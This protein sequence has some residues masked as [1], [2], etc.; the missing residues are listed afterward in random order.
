MTTTKEPPVR[1]SDE[2]WAGLDH[3]TGVLTR[4]QRLRVALL[5]GAVVA[6]PVLASVGWWFGVHASVNADVSVSDVDR[7]A[8]TF[9]VTVTVYNDSHLAQ[10]VVS[11]QASGNG[12][13]QYRTPTTSYADYPIPMEPSSPLPYRLHPDE[14]RLIHLYFRVPDCARVGV[15]PVPLSV[16]VHRWWGTTT[17][18]PQMQRTTD[19]EQAA[20]DEESGSGLSTDNSTTPADDGYWYRGGVEAICGQ[21][22][23]R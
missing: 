22:K 23:S 13:T 6:V 19:D 21:R 11:A 8:H 5:A 9:D 2:V 12:F 18:H 1:V 7:A 14:Y 17:I 10:T 3:A 15:E 20:A 16:R 4:R